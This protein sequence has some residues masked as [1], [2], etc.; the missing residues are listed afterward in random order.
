MSNTNWFPIDVDSLE[1]EYLGEIEIECDNEEYFLTTIVECDGYLVFGSVCNI[2]LLQDG[3]YKMDTDFSLDENL[4][5][6][7]ADFE[8]ALSNGVGSQ[9]EAF[10]V[11]KRFYDEKTMM[12][13]L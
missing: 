1:S 2:G 10:Q 13:L 12:V 7:L 11:N 3:W 6:L 8:D 5:E 9:S 4:Q